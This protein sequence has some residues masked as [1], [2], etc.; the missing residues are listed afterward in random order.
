[1]REFLHQLIEEY[2]SPL[3]VYDLDLA[4]RR[5]AELE[6]L[7]PEEAQH[8]LYYSFKSNPLPSLVDELCRAGCEADIASVGELRV[9]QAGGYAM[10]RALYG[11]P[12]KAAVEIREAIGAGVERF[13][14]E[15]WT[16]LDRIAREARRASKRLRVLLRVNPLEPPRARL[17]MSGVASQF[18]I[19]EE[20]ALR[21]QSRRRLERVRD[22][23][24]VD[25]VHV[26]WGTQIGGAEA[27]AACF[28]AGVAAAE[29]VSRGLGF[30][31]RVVNLGGG[32]PWP[33]GVEGER[34]DLT[35]LRDLLARI[36]AES[37]PARDAEWWFESGRYLTGATGTLVATVMDVKISKEGR[38][39]VVLDTGIHHLGGMS[40]LGRISRPTIDV[41]PLEPA[42]G[43][44]RADVVGPLCS[45][46][47]CVGRKLTLP[48]LQPGDAVRIPNVGAYGLT[49]SLTGFLSRPVP[50]E[51]AC[52]GGRVVAIHEW[53]SGHAS[54]PVPAKASTDQPNP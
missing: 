47:D 41:L 24:E 3:Y 2:G 29:R 28:R 17:A 20:D 50:R 4:R 13:S 14:V 35:P 48:R 15:S 16:E 51:I 38:R 18:G 53:R 26:Y 9:A 45:P 22:E 42:R 23:V 21:P 1:M 11:G 39:F 32:F 33:H 7:L 6:S 40:G 5:V 54:L 31:L 34:P 49:A 46:L 8:R 12:G 10:T 37:G 27:L 44:M 25:G 30:P 19:E 52:R 36:H 43:E